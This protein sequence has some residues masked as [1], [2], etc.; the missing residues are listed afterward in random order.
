MFLC[1][2]CHF[3]LILIL[4]NFIG[5][6]I[7]GIWMN[8]VVT[9]WIAL[10][11]NRSHS[12]VHLLESIKAAQDWST[13]NILITFTTIIENLY[14]WKIISRFSSFYNR[15]FLTVGKRKFFVCLKFGF[16]IRDS[17]RNFIVLTTYSRLLLVLFITERVA[18]TRLIRS[19]ASLGCTLVYPFCFL[20]IKILPVRILTPWISCSLMKICSF[21]FRIN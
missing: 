3:I 12:L 6:F 15:L 11:R 8:F 10:H 17:E 4:R 21:R 5:D 7:I 1:W 14:S 19:C 9:T 13:L 18:S 16:R 2:S 20:L